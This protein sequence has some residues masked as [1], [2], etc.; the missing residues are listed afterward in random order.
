MKMKFQKDQI[1]RIIRTI[2]GSF[3]LVLG[4]FKVIQDI[5]DYMDKPVH[6]PYLVALLVV[7]WNTVDV[8]KE[9]RKSRDQFV[10]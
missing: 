2:L 5:F 9:I 7:I 3:L 1:F 6:M 8:V 10:S 4:L